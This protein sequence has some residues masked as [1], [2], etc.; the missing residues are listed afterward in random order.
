M[1]EVMSESP[2][3]SKQHLLGHNPPCAWLLRA[4][5][6]MAILSAVGAGPAFALPIRGFVV[7]GT[8]GEPLPAA[9]V[10]L[11]GTTRGAVSNLDGYF[12]VDD[13]A[14]G[15]HAIRVSYIGYRDATVRVEITTELM[16][17]L[18]VE[19]VPEPLAME[20]IEVTADE[21]EADVR[22]SPRVSTVPVDR[23][24]IRSLPSLAAEMDV[25]RAMQTIPGVKAS[26]DLNSAAYVRGGSP[27]Q[28]LILMDHNVVY[29][30]SHMFGLFSTFNAD[31]V[32][33][34]EL[35]KG[36]FPAQ[37]GGRSGSV[38][39]VIT[40]EG[41]R[42]RTEGMASLGIVSARL[43]LEGPLRGARGSYA[44]SGRRTY[45]EPIVAALRKAYDTDDIP[46]YFFYDANGK[47]NLDLS[48]KGT[49]SLAGY[50]GDDKLTSEFGDE[51][52]RMVF[53][54]KWGNRSLT[55]RL[56]HVVGG[57]FFLSAGASWSKYRSGWTFDDDGVIV[58]DALNRLTDYSL[59]L[60][61][62]YM[63]HESHRIKTGA[64]LSL[65]DFKLTDKGE[66][67]TWVSVDTTTYNLS[68]YA[69]DTW[70]LGALLQIEPGVRAYYHQA[71]DHLRADPRI[72]IA[73]YLQPNMRLKLSGGRYTQWINV[74]SLGEGFSNFDIWV[75]VD[76]SIQPSFS[77]QGILGFEWDRDDG[78]E[79]TAEAYY[80]DMH[81][82]TT[83]D[84]LGVLQEESEVADDAFVIGDG[85]AYGAEL[86]LRRREG[87]L[88]GWLGYSLSW[89]KRRYPDS[90]ING[91]DW[92]YPKWDRRHDAIAVLSY[93]LNDR[94]TLSGSWRYNTGQGYTQA[95]GVYTMRFAD[96]PEEYLDDDGRAVLPGSQNNY[97]FPADHRLDLTASWNHTFFGLPA[98]LNIS[99]YNA[100]SR[101][102]YW[103]RYF[104]TSEN[105]VEITDVKLLPILPLL[106][107]EVRF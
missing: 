2:R 77:N 68:I 14:P 30:P 42:N 46:D 5:T 13:L 91:G 10:W 99:V 79:V 85:R 74:L 35:I 45:L 82:V 19:L 84:V 89:T 38:L 65:Y 90:Y 6:A 57:A 86:M 55:S 49:L 21:E 20:P 81:D 64:W 36:G 11:E 67:I 26:S 27:D 61:L 62:E 56:R 92:F 60:D 88:T 95:L 59:K 58:E 15:R 63:G 66:D 47:V 9:N 8:S 93:N 12:V 101:R 44:V 18:R 107:Y 51:D 16:D 87:R 25:L 76:G 4:V 73:Y 1:Q 104:D 41:N 75:P 78:V 40:N 33:H 52:D 7:D 23:Q 94:W 17:P 50:W 48:D 22:T 24:T 43:A 3:L 102:A 34:I 83:F 106:S 53:L 37:Y 39:H 28:T 98:K 31:A 97:R 100:Y 32:K 29:N 103:N 105:P 70:K 71:G 69:Q 80:T 96:M 54:A 72:A